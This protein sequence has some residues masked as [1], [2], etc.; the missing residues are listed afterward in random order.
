MGSRGKAVERLGRKEWEK[1][2]GEVRRV[3]LEEEGKRQKEAFSAS[4]LQNPGSATGRIINS[5]VQ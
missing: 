3:K 5:A 1:G 2:D 4:P